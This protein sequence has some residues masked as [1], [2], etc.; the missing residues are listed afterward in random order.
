MASRDER[1]MPA[2]KMAEPE[3]RR[4]KA[5]EMPHGEMHEPTEAEPAR[6]PKAK[7]AAKKGGGR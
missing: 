6:K 7:R 1:K 4:P 5:G 2:G 3:Q